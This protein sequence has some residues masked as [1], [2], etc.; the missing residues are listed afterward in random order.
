VKVIPTD[1]VG[2]IAERMHVR[3]N[4]GA[5]HTAL[6]GGYVVEGHVPVEAIT[7]P[8]A[9]KPDVIGIATP[10]MPQ[11]SPGMSGP[12]EPFTIYAFGPLGES[13]VVRF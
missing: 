2:G 5:C 1:D 6:I 11:G 12:K 10:G 7:K 4:M 8:I 13:T 3:A 9:E